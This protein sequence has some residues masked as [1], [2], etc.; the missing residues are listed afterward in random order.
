[1]EKPQTDP[2][3]EHVFR[4]T[5]Q[6]A[7]AI[8]KRLRSETTLRQASSERVRCICFGRASPHPVDFEA[9]EHENEHEHPS[10]PRG[11]SAAAGG[12]SPTGLP[13]ATAPQPEEAAWP[14]AP[15]I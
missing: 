4:L 7:S 15:E 6:E 9:N 8:E 11:N 14:S 10:P 2:R 13:C 12:V 5:T 3:D 1:M